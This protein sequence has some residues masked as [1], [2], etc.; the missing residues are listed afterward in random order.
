MKLKAYL[1]STIL[2][3]AFLTT[4]LIISG[5][6]NETDTTTIN[7]PQLLKEIKLSNELSKETGLLLVQITNDIKQVELRLNA[8]NAQAIE[9][10]EQLAQLQNS[11]AQ[12]EQTLS[13][14]KALSY[15]ESKNTS[16]R[17][18]QMDTITEQLAQ[19]S[20][21]IEQVEEGITESNTLSKAETAQV[22]SI[23][24]QYKDADC[25][26]IFSKES[27]GINV[28]SQI[29]TLRAVSKPRIVRE[30]QNQSETYRSDNEFEAY[31]MDNNRAYHLEVAYTGDYFDYA[32]VKRIEF[33]KYSSP[34]HVI[35]EEEMIGRI[36]GSDR[37][38]QQP[39][40][41][42]ILNL[43]GIPLLMLDDITTIKFI[44]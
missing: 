1:I 36:S 41:Y 23:S 16:E 32:N 3:G 42:F 29:I 10:D 13:Q 37:Q 5:C 15:A 35:D 24:D 33:I 40:K 20:I 22:Q 17:L 7:D 39:T 14:S 6:S 25:N 8:S 18:A 43:E 2:S 30:S 21:I 44:D 28:K 9:T 19:M 26:F 31:R 38:N 4:C 11:N 12:I 34:V 27:K